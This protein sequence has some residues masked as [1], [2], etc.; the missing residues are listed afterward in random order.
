MNRRLAAIL[1]ADMVGYSRLMA[2][3]E[4]GT[5]ARLAGCRKEVLDPKIGAF[6]GRIVK[7]T[8]DGFLAEFPSVVD[9]VRCAVVIQLAIQDREREAP[10]DQRVVYRMGINLGD[11][12]VEGKDIYGDGVNVAARLEALA[13]PGGVLVSRMVRDQVKGKIASTFEDLGEHELKNIPEPLQ[14]YRVLMRKESPEIE[15]E[16][17]PKK[18]SSFRPAFALGVLA[19]FA[20]VTSLI[21]WRPG[22]DGPERRHQGEV[23]VKPSIVVLPFENLSGPVEGE[24]LADGI[25]ETITATLGQIPGLFVISRNSAFSL[26]ERALRAQEVSDELG[27]RYILEGSVQHS[28]NQI[29]VTAQL[30]DASNDQNLWA[31][32]YD[33]DFGNIFALQDEI[34][35][36]VA[37]ALQV[38]L[39]EG[40]Q[41]N[42]RSYATDDVQAYLFYVRAQEP[43]RTFTREGMIKARK[44]AEQALDI[45][46][47]YPSALI[48]TAWTYIIDARFDYGESREKSVEKAAAFLTKAENQH[49]R[50]SDGVR[51]E[52]LSARAFLSLIQGNN[53]DA[54]A[55][56]EESVTLAPNNAFIAAVDGM[57]LFFTRQYQ[58]AI[59]MFQNAMKLNPIYPSWYLL[60]LS[61]AHVFA[62]QHDLALDVTAEGIERAEGDFMRGDHHVRAAF[63][64]ADRGDMDNAKKQIEIAKTLSPNVNLQLY[65]AIM[66]F[67]HEQ[68]WDRFAKTM[69]EAGLPH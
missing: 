29:R 26:K 49:R 28:G 55:L 1:A 56:G 12:I 13:D 7:T 69:Q 5:L 63:A 65:R 42:L 44:L 20:A 18:R 9:A 48:L 24:A 11:V 32:Q 38:E 23:A 51:A 3:D 21:W 25:T 8:G 52:L 27:V 6:R 15:E 68:D 35:L 16:S 54:I 4:P 31:D 60:W 10:E 19:I 57:I 33:R 2:A 40:E 62:D 67:Q 66:H 34:A 37:I 47:K 17:A 36:R 50:L 46:P 43:F 30:V 39:T 59:E 22:A 64:H 53:V 45:D 61:A 14:V 41:A 58:G